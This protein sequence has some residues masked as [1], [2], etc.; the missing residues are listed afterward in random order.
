MLPRLL[1]RDE[2]ADYFG[3]TPRTISNWVRART[4]PPPVKIG[5]TCRWLESDLAMVAR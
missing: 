4:F 3:V 5:G 2:V 1:S